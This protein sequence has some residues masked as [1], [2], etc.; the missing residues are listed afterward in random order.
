MY[1]LK[2]HY[3]ECFYRKDKEN[4][5]CTTCGKLI[6]KTTMRVHQRMHMREQG[7]SEVDSK[8]KIYYYCD[9]CGKKVTTATGLATHKK[10]IHNPVPVACSVCGLIFPNRPKLRIHYEKEHNPKQCKHCDYK[11]GNTHSLKEHMAKHFDPKF[12]CS[13]CEK[14]LKSK[15]AL[16]AHERDHTGER[17]YECNDCGKG[18]KSNSVLITHRK[19]V[20]KILTPGMTP[21]EKRARKK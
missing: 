19:H 17:P 6:R 16:E 12:K 15:R 1:E 4:V 2:S 14:M 9:I 13:H 11:T 10:D 8:T 3:K 7:I 21:I 5:V 20:H 18:F